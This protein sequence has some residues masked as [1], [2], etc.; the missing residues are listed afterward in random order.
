LEAK[1][2]LYT[3]IKKLNNISSLTE[4][5]DD[6][7]D[8]LADLER[9][10]AQIRA[11]G[12]QYAFAKD[13][14]SPKSIDDCNPDDEECL[15]KFQY[16]GKHPSQVRGGSE[17]PEFQFKKRPTSAVI[18]QTETEIKKQLINYIQEA[19]Y[20]WLSTYPDSAHGAIIRQ[21][22]RVAKEW[23]PTLEEWYTEQDYTDSKLV[24]AHKT[25]G[26]IDYYIPGETPLTAMF[27]SVQSNLSPGSAYWRM[28][29]SVE[30]KKELSENTAT[31][32]S[33]AKGHHLKNAD[34]EVVQ[35][36]EN[37]PEGLRQA[38]NALYANYTALN[39]KTSK[40]NNMSEFEERFNTALNESLTVN[41]SAGTDM[42]DTVN[43]TATDE[44]AHALVAILKAAGLPYKEQEAKIITTTPCGEQVEEEYAN[45][46]DKKNMSVD[47]MVNQLSGGLGKQQKMYRKEYPGDN[48]M[49]VNEENL[50]RG[51]WNLYK[52]VK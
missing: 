15:Q 46:P 13:K 40:E 10:A 20:E 36:F 11:G 44:D 31:V 17:P 52:E 33:D 12:G 41:T 49:A 19:E 30:N 1:M 2:N 38:R 18:N 45:E 16:S 14:S 3:I 25:D 8:D 35:T 39:V 43:V 4:A 42:P 50:M 34:G 47:Y 48:P 9:Q 23:A 5:S 32:F 28:E 6:N 37:T 51:L 7:D 22:Q 21:I 27:I 29:E 24:S 26:N